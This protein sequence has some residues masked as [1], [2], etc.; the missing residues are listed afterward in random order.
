M[1]I[2]VAK[3]SDISEGQLR[4]FMA[5]DQKVAVARI[6]GE[7]FCVNDRC[8]H[9]E[10]SLSD[11]WTEEK[12]IVCPCHGSSFDMKTGKV[13]SL[14]ATSDIAAYEIKEESGNILINI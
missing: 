3:S 5:N 8:S 7:L 14:P 2:K 10:C 1:F 12:N 6:D 9:E 11:G 4:Y 13:L